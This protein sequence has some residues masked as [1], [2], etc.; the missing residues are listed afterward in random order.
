MVCLS[1]RENIISINRI[2][3]NIREMPSL[4]WTFITE[5]GLY[6]LTCNSPWQCSWWMW[7]YRTYL[8]CWEYSAHW[9]QQPLTHYEMTHESYLPE[10]DSCFSSRYLESL[11]TS[12]CSPHFYGHWL[13]ITRLATRI[14]EGGYTCC[15]DAMI[16][17]RLTE[18]STYRNGRHKFAYSIDTN[19]RSRVP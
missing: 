1:I 10:Y 13:D 14:S 19:S 7:R 11:S 18:F 15:P 5:T 16:G 9:P 3:K 2:W 12:Q 8:E 4:L 6:G 17:V